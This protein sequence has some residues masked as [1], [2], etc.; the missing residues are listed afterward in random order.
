MRLM[1]IMLL[2]LPGAV[3]ATQDAWPALYDVVDVANDDVLNIRAEPSARSE[4]IG[5]FPPDRTGIEVL[6][7]S[8]DYRWGLVNAGERT[9]WVSL[10]F[11]VAQPGQWYGAY[12][13]ISQCSGTEPFW[14]LTMDDP[15]KLGN[16]LGPGGEGTGVSLSDPS[17]P[18]ITATITREAVAANRRD[19]YAFQAEGPETDMSVVFFLQSCN[20]GMSDREYGIMTD[21]L[22]R[23]DGEF[24]HLSGCCSLS[25]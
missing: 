10:T 21:I 23:R 3:F 17:S 5:S 19:R 2:L 6:R 9:G 24:S 15:S 22:L 4:I 8:D 20:D 11:L 16:L 13:R 12:P 14:S 1:M 25:R 7:P 18:T